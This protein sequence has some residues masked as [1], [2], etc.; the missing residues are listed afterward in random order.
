MS[1]FKKQMIYFTCSLFFS[2][3][4]MAMDEEELDT[5]N[6][7]IQQ[8]SSSQEGTLTS[9]EEEP[10]KWIICDG[11]KYSALNNSD[12]DEI[13]FPTNVSE[14]LLPEEYD[15]N[16][17]INHKI[18]L[19][20]VGLFGFGVTF[21]LEVL[22]AT[23]AFWGVTDVISIRNTKNNASYRIAALSIGGLA[24]LRYIAVHGLSQAKQKNYLSGID[25]ISNF[26]K[27]YK[28]F[29]NPIPAIKTSVSS[30]FYKC[31]NCWN[32]TPRTE[33]SIELSNTSSTQN[34]NTM[35][36]KTNIDI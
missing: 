19:G 17:N 13:K 11:K 4:L 24:L 9:S 22:G 6:T 10:K 5:Q 12:L 28:A 3:F 26:E 31:L 2:P 32:S 35:K 1:I 7:T 27:I 8:I 18:A 33:S 36:K 15:Q 23:G 14:L 29:E 20:L 21:T 16:K 30:I 34:A 25:K